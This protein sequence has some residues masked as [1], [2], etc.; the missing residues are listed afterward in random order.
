MSKTP[1]TYNKEQHKA[2]N[3]LIN[4]IQS[5]ANPI[6]VINDEIFEDCYLEKGMKAK[7]ISVE[8]ESSDSVDGCIDEVFKFVLDFS[9][10]DSFNMIFE[11]ANFHN[12][13]TGEYDLTAS[14]AGYKPKDFKESVFHSITH[15][16]IFFDICDDDKTSKLINKYKTSDFNGSY[17]EWLESL[18]DI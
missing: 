10:F 8:N 11:T 16:K 9:D 6:V 17:V 12:N 7:I 1:Y 14:V 15:G 5:G 4:L 13:E 2:L 3:G 18:V